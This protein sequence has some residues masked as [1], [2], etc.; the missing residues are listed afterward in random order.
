V[1]DG[2]PEDLREPAVELDAVRRRH[3]VAV[4]E[5]R[6]RVRDR[7]DAQQVAGKPRLERLRVF[8]VLEPDDAVVGDGHTRDWRPRTLQ[9]ELEPPSRF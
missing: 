2:V 1:I 6:Q 5:S 4:A 8:A 3:R 9:L 7:P